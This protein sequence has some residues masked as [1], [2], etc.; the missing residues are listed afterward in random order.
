M[1]ARNVLAKLYVAIFEGES[2]SN[3]L[4]KR[5]MALFRG[6]R[7]RNALEKFYVAL[8]RGERTVLRNLFLEFEVRGMPCSV[9]TCSFHFIFLALHCPPCDL[10][11]QSG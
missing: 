10:Q 8:F 11:K 2:G 3:V 9:F 6:E 4:K 7:V 5:Y 1:S